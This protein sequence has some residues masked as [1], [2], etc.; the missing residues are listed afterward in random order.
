MAALSGF[1]HDDRGTPIGT[2]GPSVEPKP[3]RTAEH[4]WI[5]PGGL[6]AAPIQQG[7]ECPKCERVYA[8]SVAMCL[9]CGPYKAVTTNT[10][11]DPDTG[12]KP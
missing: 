10:S 1:T 11:H 8:P 6:I 5:I 12:G 4:E 2:A 3:S 9:Y 7:W